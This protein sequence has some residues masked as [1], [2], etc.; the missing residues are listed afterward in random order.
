ML[1][2]LI[3]TAAIFY[4]ILNLTISRAGGKIDATLNTF[5]YSGFGA[6]ITLA[7]WLVQRLTHKGTLVPTTISS[8]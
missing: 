7:I 5:I 4:A 1:I 6:L 3:I 8:Y 2:A